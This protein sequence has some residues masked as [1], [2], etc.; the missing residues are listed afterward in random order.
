MEIERIKRGIALVSLCLGASGCFEGKISRVEVIEENSALTS[1]SHGILVG[2]LAPLPFP[3]PVHSTNHP[4]GIVVGNIDIATKTAAVADTVAIVPIA[5]QFF[6]LQNKSILNLLNAKLANSYDDLF[7]LY[8]NAVAAQKDPS[9]IVDLKVQFRI[10]AEFDDGLIV[11][12]T[13]PLYSLF[14][15][16]RILVERK[17]Q[18]GAGYVGNSQIFIG[19]AKPTSVTITPNDYI[20][21]FSF[22]DSAEII[23]V[24]TNSFV[25]FF[26]S[27]SGA[28]DQRVYS[29]TLDPINHAYYLNLLVAQLPKFD[30]S[31]VSLKYDLVSPAFAAA[32][33]A[34]VSLNDILI[35]GLDTKANVARV[36]VLGHV[37]YI[38][39]ELKIPCADLAKTNL[40]ADGVQCTGQTS[41]VNGAVDTA[42][43]PSKQQAK[44]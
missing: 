42:F 1:T 27:R 12:I 20:D 15:G 19:G 32:Y 11:G 38:T 31:I 22:K 35:Y 28:I 30:A 25:G 7:K 4:A 17:G 23:K 33:G 43:A 36:Y 44:N 41:V 13:A 21:M 5:S 10:N 26:G 29:L 24:G 16:H 14:A 6:Y 40:L 2:S 3:F 39:K 34:S 37:N 9:T 8:T 18:E